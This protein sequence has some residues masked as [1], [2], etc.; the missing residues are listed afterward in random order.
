MW[1]NYIEKLFRFFIL[2]FM[3]NN[4]E[5]LLQQKTSW[6]WIFQ[7]VYLYN[8]TL[9]K[10]S[11]TVFPIYKICIARCQLKY[12]CPSD[13]GG[14]ERE[15]IIFSDFPLGWTVST[16]TRT[17]IRMHFVTYI[18]SSQIGSIMFNDGSTEVRADRE[19]GKT[20]GNEKRSNQT[21]QKEPSAANQPFSLFSTLIFNCRMWSNGEL[22]SPKFFSFVFFNSFNK[23]RNTCLY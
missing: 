11:T 3:L 7:S 9:M 15:R 20:Q 5:M 17:R 18:T 4:V 23:F 14:G 8:N 19:L 1:I 12:T 22:A 16:R 6:S 13:A 10:M 21:T 2:N